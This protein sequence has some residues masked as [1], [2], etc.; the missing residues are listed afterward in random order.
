MKR[1]SKMMEPL[2]D[3]E[4]GESDESTKLKIWTS[5]AYQ[6]WILNRLTKTISA[7][8]SLSIIPLPKKIHKWDK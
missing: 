3:M 8:F 6:S 1:V 4:I 2:K 5:V 7:N